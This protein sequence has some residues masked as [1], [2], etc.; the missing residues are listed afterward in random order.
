MG[1]PICNGYTVQAKVNPFAL[2]F[3]TINELTVFIYLYVV[4]VK[5]NNDKRFT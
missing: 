5:K 2:T 1:N 4:S 3:E